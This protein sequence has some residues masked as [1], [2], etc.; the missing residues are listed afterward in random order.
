M[1]LSYVRMVKSSFCSFRWKLYFALLLRALFPAVYLSVRVHILGWNP[2][3]GGILDIA[4]QV[5][6]VQVLFKV[7]DEAILQPLYYC[8]GKNVENRDVIKNR[9]VTGFIICAAVY[10][11]FGGLL[12]LIAW[13]MADRMAQVRHFHFLSIR[14]KP[15][16]DALWL[17]SRILTIVLDLR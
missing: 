14:N 6:W 4:S 12:I 17:Q 16:N 10:L 7:C 3:D 13:P 15:F 11:M 8:L 1:A 9:F 2:K 5:A